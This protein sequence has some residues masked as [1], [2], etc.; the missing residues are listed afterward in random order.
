MMAQHLDMSK[1][2]INGEGHGQGKGIGCGRNNGAGVSGWGGYGETSAST[3]LHR[4]WTV[5]LFRL[6][7]LKIHKSHD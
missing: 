2:V 7:E 5:K 6:V 1:R 3:I 4:H